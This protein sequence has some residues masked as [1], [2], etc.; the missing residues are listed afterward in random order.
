MSRIKQALVAT[1][2]LAAL[3][4][5]G[6]SLGQTPTE[7]PDPAQ[8]E[9]GRY[10][11]VLGDCAACHTRPGGEPFSGGLPIHSAVGTI[12]TTNITPD[13]ETG[14]GSWSSDAFWRAMHNGR[15]A[16]GAHLY[17]AFPYPYFT[18]ISR[19]ESDA[20]RAYLRSQTPVSYRPPPNRLPFPLNI[21]GVM[22]VWNALFFRPHEFKPRPDRS[23]QWNRGAYLVTGLGHCG[24]C[25]TPKNLLQADRSREAQQG[26]VIEDWFAP[27]LTGDP[28]GGLADWS[29]AEL[30]E[31]LKTGRNVRTNGS[32][33]M[34]DVLVH[35]TSLTR[36]EDLQAIAVYLKSLP[37]KRPPAPAGATRIA[38]SSGAAIYADQCS[39]CHGPDGA[40]EPR[41]FP[42]LRGNANVQSRDAT[43][44]NRYILTGSPST[45]TARQ[46]TP[47]SMPAFAWKL[48]DDQIA[49][50]STYV[51]N[52][53]GNQAPA[54]SAGQV[55]RLRRKVAAHPQK[56]PPGRV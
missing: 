36:D 8:V 45:A 35:S 46:P 53:W 39:A 20:L 48:D 12:Y 31:F 18:H 9:Q 51:R 17:P 40:G 27:D 28:R 41:L 34:G 54:V 44:I 4:G 37:S 21:R 6:A 7:R 26:A 25:H 29:Q 3:S 5:A 32:A 47:L 42:P 49:A 1:L 23:P 33:S 11:A 15:R 43:T 10:L 16:N 50:V 56:P 19:G 24:G 52:S 30:V 2:S 14:I 55:A 22:V 38:M 13:S